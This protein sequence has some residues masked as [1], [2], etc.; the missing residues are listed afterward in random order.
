[1]PAI[2]QSAIKVLSRLQLFLMK[3][4]TKQIEDA[5]QNSQLLQ[6]KASPNQDLI[7]QL[8]DAMDDPMSRKLSTK[9]HEPYGLTPLMQN[10]TNNLSFLHLN[11][12]SICFHIEELRI[13]I[14][15]HKFTFD[16]IAT[17][18]S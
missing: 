3:S 7:D 10:T 2:V 16:I 18:E 13:L 9:Y 1:M 5:K 6:T 15:E 17:S 8:N 12:S 11:I 4:F 14:S